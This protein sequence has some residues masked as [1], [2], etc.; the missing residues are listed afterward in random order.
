M[1][2]GDPDGANIRLRGHRALAILV[3]TD[4]SD[5]I[6]VMEN[7]FFDLVPRNALQ[8]KLSCAEIVCAG[9]R[10]A[11]HV[12]QCHG[13]LLSISD[14]RSHAPS[15]SWEM[16]KMLSFKDLRLLQRSESRIQQ[17]EECRLKLKATF[18]RLFYITTLW[19]IWKRKR[20]RNLEQV[21]G[22]YDAYLSVVS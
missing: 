22:A 8:R 15:E 12:A 1:L 16:R 20:T 9:M 18:H 5:G 14:M 3:H 7:S 6:F 13:H 21:C 11:V 2:L 10:L 19:Y 17:L 4:D